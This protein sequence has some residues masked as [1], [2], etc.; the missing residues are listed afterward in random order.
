MNNMNYW[1]IDAPSVLCIIEELCSAGLMQNIHY[2]IQNLVDTTQDIPII[3]QHLCLIYIQRDNPF[4]APF[5]I[6]RYIP[7]N[8]SNS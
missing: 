3:M 7:S 4:S 8:Y 1:F 2:I 5:L 6:I